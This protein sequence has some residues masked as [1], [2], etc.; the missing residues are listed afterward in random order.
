MEILG[1][2]IGGSGIKG[3]IVDTNKG[4]FITERHRIE[5]PKPATNEAVADTIAK[6]VA[7]FNYSGPL[8]VGFPGI[9]RN[10]MAFSAANMHKSWI[11][12]HVEKLVS[13]HS[14]CDAFVLNDADAAG[15]AELHFGAGK[16][17]HGIAL[18]LT[19]GT[20]I[21]SALL[22][23]GRLQPSTELGHLEF[24]G[25]IAEKYCSDAAREK[26]DLSWPE[27]GKRFNKY[28]LHLERLFSPDLFI[29]G[30]G[31]SKKFDKYKDQFTIKADIIPAKLRNKAGIIGAADYA[32]SRM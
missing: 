29:L 27:W 6:I 24:K 31:A 21:G 20:G 22:N 32:Q 30:G 5:T 14:K 9:I 16:N 28:L 8:G 23:N 4:D 10:G 25:D 26:Y 17:Y 19:I 11:N 3:A 15:L 18:M 7:H 12:T 1:I 13:E 2:D